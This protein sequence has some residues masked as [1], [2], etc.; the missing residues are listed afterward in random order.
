MKPVFKEEHRLYVEVSQNNGGGII[1]KSLFRSRNRL[2][3]NGEGVIS[4]IINGH[5]LE[6]SKK[7]LN[8][9][10][11]HSDLPIESP[12]QRKTLLNSNMN[13]IEEKEGEAIEFIRKVSEDNEDRFVLVSF[14][15]GKDSAVVAHLVKKAIGKQPILFSNTGIEFPETVKYVRDFAKEY[16][17]ELMEYSAPNEFLDMCKKLG[18]PSRMMRWCCFV[19]KSA[20]I[21]NF[22]REMTENVL[23]FDGIRKAESNS[24]SKYPRVKENTKII[25]QL[26]AYPILEWSDLDVWSYIL[27]ENLMFNPLYRLG[28]TRVGCWA[29]PNNSK[30]DFYLTERIHPELMEKFK[31]VIMD[32]AKKNGKGKGWIK[33][34]KWT[35]RKTKYRN[36][37]ECVEDTPCLSQNNYIYLF[38]KD[39]TMK[40]LEYF[41]IFG[42]VKKKTS[43]ERTLVNI[44]GKLFDITM[45]IPGRHINV[46]IKTDKDVWLL[47]KSVHKQIQ[48]VLNCVLCGACMGT[49]PYGAIK[50]SNGSFE[51]SENK[52]KNCLN[53]TRSKNLKMACVALHYNTKRN[54]IKE[55]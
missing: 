39:I 43:G 19:Q 7:A 28:Y 55:D 52:C 54:V 49:C 11:G 3:H 15:G 45:V 16:G 50:V 27:K 6:F 36:F 41:K 10:N 31:S 40:N 35:S 14:S 24:R 51:I 37:T 44:D 25:R 53:C 20:P 5:G 18:P 46:K 29:C 4:F 33:E 22:Y 34:G 48:K 30:F 8:G 38:K 12:K 21:N 47:R 23:S 2:I 42:K 26:S 1:P 17:Y 9:N 13:E 32:F